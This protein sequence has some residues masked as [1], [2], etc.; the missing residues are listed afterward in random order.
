MN[1]FHLDIADS[2]FSYYKENLGKRGKSSGMS[3]RTLNECSPTPLK[4]K[5]LQAIISLLGTYLGIHK[6]SSG[7]VTNHKLHLS[8]QTPFQ[9]SK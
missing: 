9:D 4:P 2:T 6:N 3:N 1:R 7:N 5:P 8:T